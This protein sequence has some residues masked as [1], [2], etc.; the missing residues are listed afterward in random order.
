MI[1][2]GRAVC[3]LVITDGQAAV[4]TAETAA[5]TVGSTVSIQCVSENGVLGRVATV[6]ALGNIHSGIS[7]ANRTLTSGTFY[8]L[9]GQRLSQPRR[10]VNIASGRKILVK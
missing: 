3:Y 2:P 9:N 10:G 5:Y 7:A 4:T 6:D 1:C 8:S